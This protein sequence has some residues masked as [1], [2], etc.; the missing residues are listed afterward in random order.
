MLLCLVYPTEET[1]R[2]LVSGQK[3]S[4]EEYEKDKETDK[5]PYVI[6]HKE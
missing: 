4:S 5:E 1:E 3:S 6:L 2:E